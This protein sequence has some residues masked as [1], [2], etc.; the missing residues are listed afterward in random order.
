[1]QVPNGQVSP[2]LSF[3]RALEGLAKPQQPGQTAQA[4]A[5]A[6]PADPAQLQ[7]KT[8]SEAAQ[9]ARPADPGSA[10]ARAAADGTSYPRGSFLDIRV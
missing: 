5:T 3:F 2:G 1:M 6:K 9:A 10:A 8:Q 7:G 4:K